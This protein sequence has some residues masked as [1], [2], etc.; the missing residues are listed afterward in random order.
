MVW[1]WDC[2]FGTVPAGN[3]VNTRKTMKILDVPQSGSLAG[4]TSSRNR[5]GQYRRT[6]ASPVNPNST[7]QMAVRTRLTDLSTAYR[8]L[9]AGQ[10]SGW[11]GLGGSLTRT[12][13]LGQVYTLTGLQAYQS[14]NGNLLASGEDAVADAPSL[15]EPDP[16]ATITVTLTDAA[17]SIA[18]TPTPLDA[19]VKLLVYASPQRSAGRS[20]ESDLRLVHVSAAALATP[21][22]VLADYTARFGAPVAGNRIF[23]QVKLT[24]GGF[25]SGAL[26][27]SEVV[28]AA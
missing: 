28:S 2:G 13:S 4:Q 27:T 25:V 1:N 22:D 3:P 20:F 24:E 16:L 18:F 14:V 12:D 19:G 9:T 26:S 5:Y 8:A 7:N 23:L 10:R 15:S 6:R 11:I 17:F 21:A